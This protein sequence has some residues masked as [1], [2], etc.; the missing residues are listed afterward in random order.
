MAETQA[1]SFTSWK[2]AF[3]KPFQALNKKIGEA[4]GK[5]FHMKGIKNPSEGKIPSADFRQI[6][7]IP[8]DKSG[9]PTQH[10]GDNKQ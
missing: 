10:L 4:T 5:I 1:S 6:G 7:S 3:A 2:K 8:E 9:F